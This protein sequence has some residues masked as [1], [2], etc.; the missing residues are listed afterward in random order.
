MRALL[1]IPMVLFMASCGGGG[2]GGAG[3]A[4]GGGGAIAGGPGAAPGGTHGGAPTTAL[5]GG[6]S[7]E[8][9]AIAPGGAPTTA[10]GGDESGGG[11]AIA[12]GGGGSVEPAKAPVNPLLSRWFSQG[13]SGK[14]ICM[15]GDS[16]TSNASALFDELTKFY[17]KEGE[18]LYGV[19]SISNF[20]ENGASL[21]AFLSDAVLHGITATIAKQADLYVISYGINDVRLGLT[22]EGQLVDLLKK[23]VNRLRAGAP[24]ADI[25]LRMPNS[26][27]SS[28]IN[29]YNFVQPNAKAQ[30]YSTLLRNAYLRLENQ[31]NNVVIIDTQDLIFG[32]D[33]LPTSLYMSDQL[34][35]SPAGFVALAKVLVDVIG[36]RKQPYDTSLAAS[37]VATNVLAPYLIYPRVVEDPVYYNLVATGRWVSSS[38]VGTPNGY[39]DFDWPQNKS[40]E[41]KCGD[42]LQMAQNHVFALPANCTTGPIGQNT[43]I[44]N[45][46]RSLPPVTVTGGTVNVWRRK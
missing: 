15:V 28:N 40:G 22:T 5:G 1:L 30:D 37:A 21:S 4:S 7:G 10:L 26:L 20:G 18:A 46:G 9:S 34:H 23:V 31:W 11:S 3:A 38:V 29:G 41:I 16:T 24:N 2:G 13:L 12:P 14:T 43:R 36:Q 42:I 44:Y 6:E 33:S 25:V 8:G 32:R 39:V 19:A 45:L 17:M 35:P 27:L